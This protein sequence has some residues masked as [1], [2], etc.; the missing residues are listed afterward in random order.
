MKSWSEYIKFREN[1]E[2]DDTPSLNPSD[3]DE[4]GALFRMTRLAWKN[5]RDDTKSFFRKLA[6]VDPELAGEYQRLDDSNDLPRKKNDLDKEQLCP[7]VADTG[8]GMEQD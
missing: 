1:S 5:H 3:M 2:E 8:I 4:N 6:S 7:P